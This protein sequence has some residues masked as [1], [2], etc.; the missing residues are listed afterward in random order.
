MADRIEAILELASKAEAVRMAVIELN[1]ACDNL[2]IP[3]PQGLARGWAD[4]L[5]FP[6]Q[7]RAVAERLTTGTPPTPEET[8]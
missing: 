5:V 4:L 1:A 7:I 8:P 2:H 3:I 6:G